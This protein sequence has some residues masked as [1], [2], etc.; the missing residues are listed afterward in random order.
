M[1]LFYERKETS[2][3]I[4]IRYKYMPLVYIVLL[5]GFILSI[6]VDE[7]TGASWGY[8]IWAFIFIFLLIFIIDIWKPN[9]ETKKAMKDGYVKVSGSRYSFSNPYTVVIK[10]RR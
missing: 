8:L 4:I 1:A 10:K 2:D 6:L 3:E 5:G 7:I 9:K